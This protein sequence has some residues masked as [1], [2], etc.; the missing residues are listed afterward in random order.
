M[1]FFSFFCCSHF[2]LGLLIRYPQGNDNNELDAE[3]FVSKLSALHSLHNFM[4]E[5]IPL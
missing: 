2:P 5:R 3:Y 4:R 1:S